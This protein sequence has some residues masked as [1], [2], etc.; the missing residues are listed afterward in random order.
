M[1][2][3][4]HAAAN[5]GAGLN[6]APE[7]PAS[8]VFHPQTFMLDNGME[9]V[10][11]GNHR[12]PVVA[13]W[14]WYKVGTADSPPG[15]SGLPHFLE[16]LMFKGTGEIPPGAFSKI[17]AR[18]GGNDN[19]MTSYDSTGY[20][21]MIA[22]DR[23]ELVM[24]MEADRMVNLQLSDEH[25]YPERDV[26]LEE[27]RSRVD[28]EPSALLGEQ[29]MAAQYLHHP[30][31]LPVIGWF[32]EI[33]G[34]TREDALEFYRQ[35]YAPNNAVLVVAGD[36]TAAELRPLAERTYGAVSARHVPVRRRLA[37]PP[38]HAERRIALHHERVRQPVLLRSWLAPSYAS[39]GREHSYAMELLAEILGGG[40][41]SRLFRKVVVE[42]SLAAGAGCFYR[43]TG[44]DGATFRVYASPR[45]DVPMAEIEGAVAE[46]IARVLAEGVTEPELVRTRQRLIAEA[47]YARDSLGGAARVFGSALTSGESVGDVEAWPARIAA[48][49][50]D[51]VHAAARQ[52]FRPEQS[53]TALLLP[54]EA[55]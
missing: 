16:H 37:E 19:A 4:G 51:Q 54:A 21:Q 46:E 41:T 42:R 53:V 40:G 1:T 14:V 20:F 48:V 29:L 23:L 7:V 24:A 31:R 8:G 55:A 44:L 10:V 49:T 33:A 43:G 15:K 47:I 52:V 12:A 28:N 25:V 36:V 38:Q 26:I 34:Y 9:V 13:H 39:P 2:R 32:H 18:L 30:Y 11:V 27:R 50:L 45:P 5:A 6:L 22:K 17:V 35:W 3:F